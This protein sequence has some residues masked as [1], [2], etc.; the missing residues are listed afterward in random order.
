MGWLSWERYM[1]G[2][3]CTADPDGC[4]SENL[5]LVMG[6][7]LVAGGYR[8]AG[9]VYVCVRTHPP[10]PLSLRAHPSWHCKRDSAEDWSAATSTTSRG[11]PS[12]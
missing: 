9:Y 1:C 11:A 4:I 10:P 7:Q 6:D 2:I 12:L 3:D 8:D 5:Y